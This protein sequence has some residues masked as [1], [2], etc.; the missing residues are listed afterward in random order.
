[1][2]ENP[3]VQRQFAVQR[4]Y[5]KDISFE[6]PNSPNIFKENWTP[7]INVGLGTEVSDIG[8]GAKEL[9]LKVT[10]DA[11]HEGKS[12]FLVEV[13][14]AGIFTVAGFTDEEVDAVMNIGAANVVFPYARETISDLIT[15][16]S[17]PQFVLQPVN[18]EALYAQQRQQR[19]GAAANPG[20]VLSVVD[21][22]IGIPA[23]RLGAIF[24]QFEQADS[25]TTRRF[26]GTGLGLAISRHLVELMGGVIE[27]ESVVGVGSTFRVRLPLPASAASAPDGST[28]RERPHFDLQALVADDNEINRRV[29]EMQLERLGVRCLTVGDGRQVLEELTSDIDF[30]LMDIQMPELDGLETVRRIRQRT[31]AVARV[32]VIALTGEGGDDDAERSREAGMDAHLA[33][34]LDPD[35]L[36][37]ML[38][39]RFGFAVVGAAPQ[40]V[41]P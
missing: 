25:D 32:P 5:V 9:A 1:M 4:I 19:A 31:D 13:V 15:R 14:Q 22:G 11:K 18:F 28:E 7:Q 34:P 37:H 26:G 30:V 21:S 40:E 16:G 33:K 29:T 10:V 2:S 6:S 38:A 3:E 39:H 36:A 35:A 12:V 23:D 20:L 27:V 41:R 24:E 8:N 17:F